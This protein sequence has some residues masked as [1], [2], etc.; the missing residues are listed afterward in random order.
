MANAPMTRQQQL[1]AAQQQN[2]AARQFVIANAINTWQ[3]TSNATYNGGMGQTIQLPL[4]NVGLQ[5]RIILEVQA[6]VSGTGGGPLHTLTTLGGACFFSNVTLTDLNQQVR[7]NTPSWHLTTIASA[8]RR[9]PYGSAIKTSA[10]DTPFGYGAN[11]NKTQVAPAT[12]G[13]VVTTP[14]VFLMFELPLAYSDSDLRGALFANIVTAT[15]NL[16]MTVNPNL[17]VGNATD[18]SLSM[19]Q[20]SSAVAATLP[21]VTIIINQ[22]YLD[23]LPVGPNGPVLPMLDLATA[24]IL[25]QSQVSGL[26]V[27]AQNPINYPNSRAIL[28]TTV[29]YDDNSS[30]QAGKTTNW[31]LQSANYTAFTNTDENMISLWNRNRLQADFPAGM[32]YLDHR[33]KPIQTIQFGNIQLLITPSTVTG[34]A[35][36]FYYGLEMLAI[37]NQVTSA[38]SLQG[39]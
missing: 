28:S 14:N 15:Y 16:S 39:T 22:N 18:P 6:T 4:R 32:Y 33:D 25:N 12:I 23:Q 10:T 38:G 24:Y 11:Y 3:Q 27:N 20:S 2:M 9:Q 34:A 5:K 36:T 35:S 29:L 7:I 17:C 1:Q 8:K 19:Y 26:V 13:A 37:I 21:S 30:L 31:Q